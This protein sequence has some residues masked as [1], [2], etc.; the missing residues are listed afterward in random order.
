ML[1]CCMLLSPLVQAVSRVE[2]VPLFGTFVG[3][4]ARFAFRLTAG[5]DQPFEGRIEVFQSGQGR[6][7]VFPLSVGQ[8]MF[9]WD[10]NPQLAVGQSEGYEV[11]VRVSP[12]QGKPIF[13][14]RFAIEYSGQS[15]GW[16]AREQVVHVGILGRP[17][18]KDSLI[19]V[20]SARASLIDPM[21][22]P[23][24]WRILDNLDVV[25]LTGPALSKLDVQAMDSLTRW[26]RTGGV[27]LLDSAFTRA[28]QETLLGPHWGVSHV[29]E[30]SSVTSDVHVQ[31]SFADPYVNRMAGGGWSQEEPVDDVYSASLSHHAL[32]RGAYTAGAKH[33]QTGL[34]TPVG[35]GVLVLLPVDLTALVVENKDAAGMLIT[36]AVNAN[37]LVREPE[38]ESYGYWGGDTGWG[39]LMQSFSDLSPISVGAVVLFFVIFLLVVGPVEFFILRVLKRKQLTWIVTPLLIAVACYG[40]NLISVMTRGLE[41]YRGTLSVVDYGLNGGGVATVYECLISAGSARATLP[42]SRERRFTGLYGGG[43][44]G[45]MAVLHPDGGVELGTRAWI[46][47]TYQVQIAHSDAPLYDV[48]VK[49]Q[50]NEVVIRCEPKEGAPIIQRAHVIFGDDRV[51]ELKAESGGV[52]AVKGSRWTVMDG[53]DEFRQPL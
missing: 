46:P 13:S 5:F 11:E 51:C 40:A 21:R 32:K 26:M 47:A 34:H 48:S 18:F 20:T 15:S 6:V 19:L 35:L 4:N 3:P 44:S 39:S 22:F 9:R 33:I 37:S 45:R 28:D 7:L 43:S 41:P 36:Q 2:A 27:V 17:S 23:S 31:S 25:V 12:K 16:G 30:P 29:G 24:D 42:A 53:V 52:W 38:M 49:I 50:S 8:G 14:K 10:F 1:G